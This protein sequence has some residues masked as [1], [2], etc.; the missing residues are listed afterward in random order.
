MNSP[1]R[2][3]GAGFL[4]TCQHLTEGSKRGAALPLEAVNPSGTHPHFMDRQSR[5]GKFWSVLC[6]DRQG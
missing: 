1:R 3:S 4:T 2:A 6:A 5:S